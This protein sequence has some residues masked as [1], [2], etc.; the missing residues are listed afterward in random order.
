[1]APS[2]KGPTFVFCTVCNVDFSVA[3]GGVHEIMRSSATVVVPN[4][5]LSLTVFWHSL[6]S[7]LFFRKQPSR[8]R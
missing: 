7:L 1:M 4:T 6:A 2:R 3:G 8:T 5:S